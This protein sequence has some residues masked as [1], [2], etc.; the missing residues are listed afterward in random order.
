MSDQVQ[1]CSAYNPQSK[2]PLQS[3]ATNRDLKVSLGAKSNQLLQDRWD[4][5]VHARETFLEHELKWLFLRYSSAVVI[6]VVV[7]IEYPNRV[8]FKL[9]NEIIHILDRTQ[10]YEMYEIKSL[11]K[12]VGTKIKR[13]QLKYNDLE[14]VDVLSKAQRKSDVV[15]H[16][17]ENNLRQLQDR[18]HDLEDLNDKSEALLE[19]AH[20]FDKN[21]RQ[22][23]KTMAWYKRKQVIILTGGLSA[24][25]AAGYFMFF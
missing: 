22:L 12:E 20:M 6:C 2:K 11:E 7:H 15:M 3:I 5:R 16:H 18:G 14:A 13:E 10:G 21:A 1:L 25:S 4:L 24:V 17:A 8:G 9:L 23:K 19:E